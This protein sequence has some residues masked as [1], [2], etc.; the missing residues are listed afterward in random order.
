MGDQRGTGGAARALSCTLGALLV[1]YLLG[2]SLPADAATVSTEAELQAAVANPGETSVVLANSVDLTCAGGGDLDRNSAAALTLAGKGF[3]IRQTCPGER[4]IEQAGAGA[5]TLEEVTLTGGSTAA[6]GGGVLSGGS[7]TLVRSSVV[8]NSASSG[9]GVFA[10]GPITALASTVA[11][12][13]A[14]NIG[15][16]LEVI[17]GAST[18]T[19]TNSTITGNKAQEGGGIATSVNVG[20]TAVRLRH[21]TIVGNTALAGANIEGEGLESFGSVVALK[22]GGGDDCLINGSTTTNG[23]NFSGD[24]SCGFTALTDRQSG[25]DPLLGALANNGG[26]TPTRLPQA[27][28]S[29]VDAITVAACGF[30]GVV[31]DQRGVSRPQH[32]G[33]DI[34]AVEVESAPPPSGGQP[35]IELNSGPPPVGRRPSALPA[36]R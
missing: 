12:N 26:P 22:Q 13:T 10:S 6:T 28:S 21:A 29:L 1:G 8:G 33:C 20:G 23:H 4:V 14:V 32:M 27:G 18:V 2:L 9:A 36:T 34:G 25:G 31:S 5:L 11:G 16:G 7:V 35:A 19:V 15:G 17:G 24:A 3:T 30:G